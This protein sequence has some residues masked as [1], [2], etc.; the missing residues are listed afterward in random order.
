MTDN[1]SHRFDAIILG[2]GV[3]GLAAAVHLIR[4]GKRPLVLE[5]ARQPG[6]RARSFYDIKIGERL[7]NGPHLL[8]GAYDKTLELLSHLETRHLLHEEDLPALTFWTQS[9]GYQSLICPDL[10][11][12]LHF[13][14]ALWRFSPMK[15]RDYRAV[16]HGGFQMFL[17]LA[18]LANLEECSVDAWLNPEGRPLALMAWL[19][20]P[21]TQAILNEPAQ[22]ANAAL[23]A[24]VLQRAFLKDRHAGR[25]LIPGVPLSALLAEPAQSLIDRNG[26]EV[27]LGWRVKRLIRQDGS[28]VQ[29]VTNRETL[30]VETIPVICAAPQDVLARMLPQFARETGFS[31]LETAP[32][33][34]IYLRYAVTPPVHLPHAPVVGMPESLSQWVFDLSRIDGI[35]HESRFAVVIS[36]AYQEIKQPRE[37]IIGRVCSELE[38]LLPDL[39]GKTPSYVRFVSERRATFAARPGTTGLRPGTVTPWRNLLLAGDW[40]ATGLPAT[41]EG[42][43]SSG[44]S[45]AEQVLDG[46]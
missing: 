29:I 20:K 24:N 17:D 42:A 43:V 27:R 18:N 32:I 26:G 15:F 33:L 28:L 23:L 37:T 16:I 34:S 19:L 44:L 46:M 13:L 30:T 21:L 36:G 41:L 5:S 7:D 38:A 39:R 25:L 45:A 10:P 11:A 35:S 2:A 12:P 6:G 22:S 3:A 40:T 9:E 31:R 1:L 4:A 14:T 8:I